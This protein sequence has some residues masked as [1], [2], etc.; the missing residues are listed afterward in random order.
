MAAPPLGMSGGFGG[1]GVAIGGYPTGAPRLEHK[2]SMGDAISGSI[3]AAEAGLKTL[4]TGKED[5]GCGYSAPVG[6]STEAVGN[7]MSHAYNKHQMSKLTKDEFTEWSSQMN[8][9]LDAHPVLEFPPGLGAPPHPGN[10]S[11]HS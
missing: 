11:P 4:V 5:I 6:H 7:S 10:D 2:A 9:F 3:D 8:K 1:M